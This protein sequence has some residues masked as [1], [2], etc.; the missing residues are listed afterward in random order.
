VKQLTTEQRLAAILNS[1]DSE[2]ED[3]D[4][5]DKLEAAFDEY[6]EDD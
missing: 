6:E 3:E 5:G 4:E 2:P 1:G